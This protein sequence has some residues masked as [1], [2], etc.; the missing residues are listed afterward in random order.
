MRIVGVAGPDPGHAFPV[1]AVLDALRRRG[2]EV[3]AA[4]G[5]QRGRDLDAADLPW[6]E[7]PLLAPP[8]DDAD[9]GWRMWGRPAEMTRP[10]VALLEPHRPD[11]ILFDTLT[12]VGA[13][14]AQVLDV[15][16]VEVIPHHLVDPAPDVP[17]VGLGLRPART[18]AGRA[19]AS[20]IR[21]QQ[22]RSLAQADALHRQAAATLGLGQPRDPALRLVGTLPALE[23]PRADWPVDVEVVGPLTWEPPHWPAPAVPDGDGPVVLVAGSTATGLCSDLCALALQGLSH[24]DI[25]VVATTGASLVVPEGTTASVGP[26]RHS[27]VLPSAAAA[28]VNGGGGVVA[29]ALAAGVPLVVV[30]LAGD[31]RETARRVELAGVGRA[32]RPERASPARL[33]RELSRVL[34]DPAY[35]DA[36]RRAA[37]GAA[38]P[39]VAASLVEA[40]R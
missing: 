37:T 32:V 40:L 25:R 24:T 14:A 16:F 27:A 39:D 31:Q 1:V 28:V 15:P 34:S 2:H 23:H 7:L 8:P 26:G 19:Y 5:T 22:H 4:T 38:G 12:R 30:P 17:P 29:K 21:R 10:L 13:F 3:L 18:P 33:R 11:V 35:T 9:F 20:W 36:A 6:V